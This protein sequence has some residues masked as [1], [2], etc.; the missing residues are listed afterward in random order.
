MD[1]ELGVVVDQQKW[2]LRGWVQDHHKLKC[3]YVVARCKMDQAA[4]VM[5]RIYDHKAKDAPLLVG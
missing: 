5:K 4:E 1:L 2:R 3:A